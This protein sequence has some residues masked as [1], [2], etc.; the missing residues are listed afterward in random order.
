MSTQTTREKK[1]K[2]YS[3]NKFLP[4]LARGLA[5]DSTH[6]G[7]GVRDKFLYSFFRKVGAPAALQHLFHS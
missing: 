5:S 3:Q 1:L 2:H 6:K 7:K 4:H